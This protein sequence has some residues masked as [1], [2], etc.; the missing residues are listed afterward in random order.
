[1]AKKTEEQKVTLFKNK[2]IVKQGNKVYLG[3]RDESH[4]IEMDILDTATVDGVEVA[5]NVLIQLIDNT[6]A[7]R[8]RIVRKAERENMAKAMDIAGFWLIDA[9][10]ESEEA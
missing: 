5:K 3:Y 6:K 2:P 4:M 8:D 7:G 10:G 9:L 1:M